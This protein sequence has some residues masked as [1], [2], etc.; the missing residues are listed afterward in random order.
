[1]KIHIFAQT[2]MDLCDFLHFSILN[3]VNY[4]IQERNNRDAEKMEGYV[5]QET[6]SFAWS[7]TDGKDLGHGSVRKGMFRTLCQI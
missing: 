5:R 2:S 7:K 1:M 3:S 4:G 6:G